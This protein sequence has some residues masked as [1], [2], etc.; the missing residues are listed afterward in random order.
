MSAPVSLCSR[1]FRYVWVSKPYASWLGVPAREI[2]GRP[3]AEVLGAA[4]FEQLRPHFE[5]VLG[6][7]RVEYEE[8]VDFRRLGPRWV[9]VVYTPTVDA[10]GRTD[11]WVAVVNDVED[12]HQAEARLRDEAR[13]K[14]EFLALLGHELRNPLAPILS[15][16]ELLRLKGPREPELEWTRGVIE[17]QAQHLVRLVDD[18]LDLSRLS[19]GR[20]ELHQA[21]LDVGRGRPCRGDHAARWRARRSRSSVRAWRGAAG[22]RGRRGPAG[23]GL[24]NVL[25]NATRCTPPGLRGRRRRA[26]REHGGRARER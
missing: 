12:R 6:G 23:P 15:A 18:L 13:R 14:D 3:I 25:N 4:A 22:G 11:G 21:P 20:V 1:D 2:V 16:L 17:R 8:R 10:T 9:H 5:R 7:E 19:T 24:S 26:G